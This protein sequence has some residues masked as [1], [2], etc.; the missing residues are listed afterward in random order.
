MASIFP[1]S[2]VKFF[3]AV[4]LDGTYQNTLYFDTLAD[5]LTYFNSLTPLQTLQANQY[6]RVTDGEFQANCEIGQLYNANYMMFQNTSYENKWFFALVTSVDYV[7][8]HNCRVHFTLD[9]M[10]TWMFDITLGASFIERQHSATDE[11]G[12]NIL[13]EPVSPGEYVFAEY[14]QLMPDGQTVNGL[15]DYKLAVLVCDTGTGA[16]VNCRVYDECV[17]GG[18]ITVYN[19]DA[20][21]IAALNEQLAP[22]A[23]RPEAIVAM[24]MVP[25]LAI[26]AVTIPDGGAQLASTYHG[27][28]A[29]VLKSALDGTET[30]GGYTPKNKKLYT[31]P[32]NYYHVD[33]GNGDSSA[34]RYEF[35]STGTPRFKIETCILPPVQVKLMPVN[36]KGQTGNNPVNSE[37]LTISGYPLCS[38]NYDSYKAWQAQNAIPTIIKAGVGALGLIAA[39]FT[40][41]ASLMATAISGA[42]IAGSA[43]S[44]AYQASM[45]ADVCKGNI[46]AGNV[47]FS[48][49]SMQYYGGRCHI[50]RQQA[51]V[52]DDFFTMYGYAYNK[53]SIPNPKRRPKWYYVK[54]VGANIVGSCPADDLRKIINIYDSGVTFW[55]NASEVGSYWLDNSIPTEG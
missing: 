28:S 55:H 37:F 53:V 23:A 36:Y 21:A 44:Q 5:Q 19:T 43:A 48:Q 16:T 3:T 8:D 45:H 1:S 13:P 9:V 52:I 39:P 12:D 32:Y 24:Y 2:V 46:A 4:P 10:Q 6:T 50:T 11:I 26:G 35:F 31:Y 54:T 17:A 15:K 27:Q 42:S 51:V 47:N 20:N 33:N 30:F 14:E 18:Y 49:E 7:N 41:G 22:Y 25:R 29:G 34:F 40:G 38:W